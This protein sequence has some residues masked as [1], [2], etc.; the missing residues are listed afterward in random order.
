MENPLKHLSQKDLLYIAGAIASLVGIALFVNSGRVK[1]PA[2]TV[3]GAITDAPTSAANDSGG[4][5]TGYT[6]YNVGPLFPERLTAPGDGAAGEGGCCCPSAYGC[7][8][9]SALDTGSAS[10]NLN[11]FLDY[12][13]SINPN[14]SQ[15]VEA[16]QRSYAEYFSMGSTYSGGSV[17]PLLGING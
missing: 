8:G 7:A 1:L 17:S 11:S 10:T 13:K 2:A 9:A 14:Y 16:Q 4:F 15:L 12:M 3:P 6:G 5:S